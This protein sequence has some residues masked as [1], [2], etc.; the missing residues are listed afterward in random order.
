LYATLQNIYIYTF[1][2]LISATKAS[3]LQAYIN[4]SQQYVCY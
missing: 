1:A 4:Y 2:K 3:Q